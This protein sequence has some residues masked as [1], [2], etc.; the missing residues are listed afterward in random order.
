MIAE[1]ENRRWRSGD[2]VCSRN[3]R[4]ARDIVSYWVTLSEAANCFNF[5]MQHECEASVDNC[6]RTFPA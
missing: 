2:D 5:E 3:V 6:D 4:R 1:Y